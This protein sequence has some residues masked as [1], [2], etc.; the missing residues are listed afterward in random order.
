[1][2][3]NI[4]ELINDEETIGY[5]FEK[6][7]YFHRENK[8]QDKKIDNII[9]IIL[10]TS[11]TF[12]YMLQFFIFKENFENII[13]LLTILIFSSFIL[14]TFIFSIIFSIHMMFE[15]NYYIK[16]L[17]IN[18]IYKKKLKTKILK[19]EKKLNEKE[20]EYYN[21]MILREDTSDYKY[22]LYD[23]YIKAINNTNLYS[24]IENKTIIF[25]NIK[26]N[27]DEQRQKSLFKEILKVIERKN[28][29]K[30][31]DDIDNAI[32]NLNITKTTIENI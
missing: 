29:K 4:L 11:Y 16:N 24:I 17:G 22:F 32:K 25:D 21:S 14:T 3:K 1:M 7:S 26:E 10:S 2:N 23:N 13:N 12:S 20:L 30:D 31:L 6:T 18:T 5:L 8:L 15:E 9:L 19:F 27:F 28:I